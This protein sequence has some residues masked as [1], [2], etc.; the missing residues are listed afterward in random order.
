MDKAGAA[1]LWQGHRRRP[2]SSPPHPLNKLTQLSFFPA[3]KRKLPRQCS[4]SQPAPCLLAVRELL[5]DL[6]PI[7]STAMGAC[8]VLWKSAQVFSSG[9]TDKTP[10]RHSIS[11]EFLVH[12]WVSHHVSQVLA[13]STTTRRR[14]IFELTLRELPKLDLGPNT[15]SSLWNVRLG[16]CHTG[17]ET[18]SIS[19]RGPYWDHT[20]TIWNHTKSCDC[21]GL[22]DLRTQTNKRRNGRNEGPA[23]RSPWPKC[24]GARKLPGSVRLDSRGLLGY[25]TDFDQS[26]GTCWSAA[27]MTENDRNWESNHFQAQWLATAQRH[28]HRVQLPIQDAAVDG[29]LAAVISKQCQSK[30]EVII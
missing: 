9:N 22:F 29:Q 2:S 7:D 18:A 24:L 14:R 5:I 15:N 21:K 28:I 26:Y 20:G 25:L 10:C 19:T 16:R 11:H 12:L 13:W 4:S 6:L 1:Q 17:R 3:C 8:P 23:N 27:A 30:Q